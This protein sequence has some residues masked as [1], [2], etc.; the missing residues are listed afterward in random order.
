[1]MLS[2][3]WSEW[4]VVQLQECMMNGL[5]PDETAA[6]LGK[7]QQEV[8]DKARELGLLAP[9]DEMAAIAPRAA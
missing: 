4:S 3:G 5:G 2:E 6:L 1:M 8:C 9:V 7:T